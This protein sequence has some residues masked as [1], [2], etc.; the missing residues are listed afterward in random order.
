MDEE[1]NR[2]AYMDFLS[3]MKKGSHLYNDSSTNF[4]KSPTFNLR[5]K[6]PVVTFN[7]QGVKAEQMQVKKTVP[8]SIVTME[9]DNAAMEED[10]SS[11]AADRA[12]PGSLHKPGKRYRTR[13]TMMDTD[14]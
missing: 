14:D 6:Q 8:L 1:S 10:E 4:E 13:A 11:I 3:L 12:R 9:S 5:M 7:K 2:N